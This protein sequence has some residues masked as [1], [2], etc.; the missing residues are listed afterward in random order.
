LTDAP[1]TAIERAASMRSSG[2]RSAP[3]A[4]LTS[5]S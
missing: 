4:E 1:T 2:D 5:A 3:R